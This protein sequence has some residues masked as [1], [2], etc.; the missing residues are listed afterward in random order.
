MSFENDDWGLEDSSGDVTPGTQFRAAAKCQIDLARRVD[1]AEEAVR[2]SRP[3]WI[4]VASWPFLRLWK[5][6]QSTYVAHADGKRWV[7]GAVEEQ[8]SQS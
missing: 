2:A 7:V 6:D 4:L 5:T 1:R 8:V 3:T